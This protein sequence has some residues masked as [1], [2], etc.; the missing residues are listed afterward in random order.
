MLTLNQD[1]LDEFLKKTITFKKTWPWEDAYLLRVIAA[2]DTIALDK[3]SVD[4]INEAKLFIEKNTSLFSPIR[5]DLKMYNA[6]LLASAA[7]IE[8]ALTEILSICELFPKN[9][10]EE[11]S[12]SFLAACII[13]Q[14]PNSNDI[15]FIVNQTLSFQKALQNKHRFLI[16]EQ[17]Y[18]YSALFALANLKVEATINNIENNFSAIRPLLGNNLGSLE[19]AEVISLMNK[20]T[21]IAQR[22]NK[23]YEAVK[24]IDMFFDRDQNLPLLCSLTCIGNDDAYLIELIRENYNYLKKNKPVNALLF[25]KDEFLRY[26]ILFSIITS[27]D[28]SDNTHYNTDESTITR[29]FVQQQVAS[30]IIN[31]YLT[32]ILLFNN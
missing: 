22:L 7:D 6:Y 28:E 13:Y 5:H 24:K 32:Y 26:A 1:L 17:N 16:T 3:V 18:T 19:S 14:G 25:S 11:T 4:K 12:Y 2:L 15:E 27:L 29:L 30:I 10:L 8:I 31:Y 20:G 23:L 9:I 21:Y